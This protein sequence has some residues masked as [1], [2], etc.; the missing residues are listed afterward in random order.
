MEQNK[1]NKNTIYLIII[2][3]LVAVIGYLIYMNSEKSSDIEEQVETIAQQDSEITQKSAELDQLRLEYARVAEE[4]EKL[5]LNN[6]SLN[7]QIANL[8]KTITE[9]RRTGKLNAQKRKELEDLV[10]NLRQDIVNKDLEISSLKEQVEALG[11]EKESLISEKDQMGQEMDS[12]KETEKQLSGKVAIASKLKAEGFKIYAINAKG[13]EKEGNEH[14][15]K[16]I[17]KIKITFTLG[18]NEV[19]EK[20]E[21]EF[22]LKV[23]DPL[24]AVLYD[25]SSGGGI[26]SINGEKA[27]YTSRQT[28]VFDNSRQ[29]L[30]FVYKKGINFIPG[31]HTFEIF[32][33][34]HK[35]GQTELL[36]K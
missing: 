18:E 17:D 35:I 11:K 28:L 9:L 30:E 29:S 12:L 5:G 10:K 25:L 36:V 6:D 2:I 15:S 34:G 8:D 13:K 33:E 24:G 20:N 1:S 31:K 22:L 14:K 4:R 27:F 19:A 21:K 26:F 32:C 7:S 3:A 16:N 23:T